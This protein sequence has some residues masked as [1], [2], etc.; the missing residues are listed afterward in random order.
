MWH[1]RETRRLTENTNLSLNYRA[2]S[3]LYSK[4]SWSSRVASDAFLRTT[5]VPGTLIAPSANALAICVLCFRKGNDIRRGLSPYLFPPQ[6]FQFGCY[7]R[8]WAAGVK[9]RKAR[10]LL[11]AFGFRLFWG[12]PRMSGPPSCPRNPR[13]LLCDQKSPWTA[14]QAASWR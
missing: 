9:L 6:L 2:I 1:R 12:R 14:P 13:S 4:K 8:S 10:Q 3:R 7:Y 11:Q 5:W